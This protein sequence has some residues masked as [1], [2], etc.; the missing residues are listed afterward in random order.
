MAYS[1]TRI[2]AR[3]DS[4]VRRRPSKRSRVCS[5]RRVVSWRIRAIRRPP[6]RS[7]SG[8]RAAAAKQREPRGPRS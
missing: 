8:P 5:G 1:C 6:R 7:L 3:T 4:L 2:P